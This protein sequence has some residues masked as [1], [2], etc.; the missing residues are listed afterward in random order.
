MIPPV[1]D[2][3]SLTIREKPATVVVL[4][5]TQLVRW[6]KKRPQV[7]TTEQVSWL[8]RAADLPTTW[9]T[10]PLE[11]ASAQSLSAAFGTLCAPV[12]SISGLAVGFVLLFPLFAL[13]AVG[14]GDLKLLAGLGAWFGPLA[15]LQ[16]FCIEALVGAVLVIAQAV[17]QGRTNALFRNSAVLAVNITHMGD[18]GVDHVR[19]T[20][21]ASR[22]VDRP[23]PYAVPILIALVALLA[24]NWS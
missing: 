11:P 1:V 15:A 2:P 18:V 20:G 9:H 5:A 13:G 14:G 12:E 4:S 6:L 21:E 7:F 19:S 3:Q 23:L 16:L 17:Q 8:L 10:A 22:S 24:W